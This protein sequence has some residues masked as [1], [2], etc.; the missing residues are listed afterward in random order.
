MEDHL[1]SWLAIVINDKECLDK[2]QDF[3]N[4][5]MSIPDIATLLDL[6]EDLLSLAIRDGGNP[7]AVAYKRGKALRVLAIHESEISLAYAGSSQGM[8]NLHA[9]LQQMNAAEY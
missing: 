4:K 8:D 5:L 1:D 6:E 7:V 9:F 2:I 3:A